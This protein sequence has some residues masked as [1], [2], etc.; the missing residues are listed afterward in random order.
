MSLEKHSLGKSSCIRGHTGQSDPE[1]NRFL[2]RAPPSPWASFGRPGPARGNQIGPP[3]AIVFVRNFLGLKILRAMRGNPQQ[4]MNLKQNQNG[5]TADCAFLTTNKGKV[6]PREARAFSENVVFGPKHEPQKHKEKL[7]L[8]GGRG[9]K[10][11]AGSK[12][13]WLAM[14]RAAH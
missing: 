6:F 3:T 13:R 5:V 9:G 7:T 14:G 1:S 2:G 10:K 4:P 11:N 8:G 12:G